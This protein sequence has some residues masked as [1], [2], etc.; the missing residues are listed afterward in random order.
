VTRGDPAGI[1]HYHHEVDTPSHCPVPN[2]GMKTA[3]VVLQILGK[4][5]M[6][7][8]V[9]EGLHSLCAS[10]D[11]IQFS[12]GYQNQNIWSH[13]SILVQVTTGWITSV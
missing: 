5:M 10:S 6:S 4:E 11:T 3:T 13:Y 12:Q 2:V 9:S 7:P 8:E 1:I